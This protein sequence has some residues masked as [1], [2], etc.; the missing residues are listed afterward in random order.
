MVLWLL[1]HC[2][3]QLH[4]DGAEIGAGTGDFLYLE[5]IVR[6]MQLHHSSERDA[7]GIWLGQ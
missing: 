6:H 1:A 4:G 5:P 3:V 7:D 2:W